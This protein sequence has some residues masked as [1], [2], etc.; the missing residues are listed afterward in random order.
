MQPPQAA[1]F[2][3]IEHKITNIIQTNSDTEFENYIFKKIAN[4]I[5]IIHLVRLMQ[6]CET[7]IGHGGVCRLRRI[8]PE[9]KTT[10][11]A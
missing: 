9:S 3:A 5:R 6:K 8:E 4:I 2:N 10:K 1:H 7:F 11:R